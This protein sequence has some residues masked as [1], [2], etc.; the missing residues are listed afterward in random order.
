MS[1]ASDHVFEAAMHM[2]EEDRVDLIGRLLAT[3]PEQELGLSIE[4]ADLREELDRRFA[5]HDGEVRW[6]ELRAER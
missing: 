4:S 3:M 2:S 1:Q 6:V 5:D